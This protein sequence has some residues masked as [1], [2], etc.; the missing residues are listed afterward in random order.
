MTISRKNADAFKDNKS[1]PATLA[2][3]AAA[4]NVALEYAHTAD[5][6]LVE[7]LH[8][9]AERIAVLEGVV[10]NLDYKQAGG[11]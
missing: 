4:A 3:A 11:K 10:N 7:G 5:L 1:R 6:I 9:L 2:D 8:A